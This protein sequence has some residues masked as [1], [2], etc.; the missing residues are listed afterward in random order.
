MRAL[1]TLLMAAFLSACSPQI[2]TVQ[3]DEEVLQTQQE[4]VVV[5]R[6]A[7]KEGWS[8][9]GA[10]RSGVQGYSFDYFPARLHWSSEGKD[11][12]EPIAFDILGGIPVLVVYYGKGFV[13]QS[14]PE[15][16]FSI[17]TFYANEQS[18]WIELSQEEAPLNLMTKNLLE[19]YWGSELPKNNEHISIIEK[20]KRDGVSEET[21]LLEWL[22]M[23]GRSCKDF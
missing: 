12:A 21:P 20:R 16:A 3:W 13:C 7:A 11:A 4:P 17:R 2:E 8:F 1:L 15:E 18:Q 6:S 10:Q 14:L 23:P 22:S 19:S 5:H 9:P